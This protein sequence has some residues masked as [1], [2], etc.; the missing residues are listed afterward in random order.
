MLA[1]QEPSLAQSVKRTFKTHGTDFRP[2][3]HR[4]TTKRRQSRTK[5]TRRCAEATLA[6]IDSTLQ[7][8]RTAMRDLTNLL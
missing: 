6:A 7:L 1:T 4:R 3:P 2:P 5:P 8:E